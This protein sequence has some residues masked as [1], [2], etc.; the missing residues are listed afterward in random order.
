MPTTIRNT[1]ILFNDGTTQSTAAYVQDTVN[2]YSIYAGASDT[3]S[4]TMNVI[5]TSG[6]W[7]LVITATFGISDPGN[8]DFTNTATAVSNAT[9]AT[10]SVRLYRAGGAGFGRFIYGTST[11][12]QTLTISSS[13]NTTL[14][15]GAVTLNGGDI[16]SRMG[17]LTKIA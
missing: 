13:T 14:Q 10:A 3:A 5:L 15:L 16:Q 17:V 6:T 9:T 1:D 2:T 4:K 12:V 11:G 7:Q 8:Y